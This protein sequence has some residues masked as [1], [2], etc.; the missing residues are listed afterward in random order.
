LAD[1]PKVFNFATRLTP[2][3]RTSG[4][5]RETPPLGDLGEG[6]TVSFQPT[7]STGGL[8]R[9]ALSRRLRIASR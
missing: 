9:S 7:G 8:C 4:S 6:S 1:S 2:V 5:R 3:A